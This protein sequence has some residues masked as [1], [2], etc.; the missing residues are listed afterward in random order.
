M[1]IVSRWL[2]INP[3]EPRFNF[4]QTLLALHLVLLVELNLWLV[5]RKLPMGQRKSKFVYEFLV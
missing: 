2:S 4:I 1:L 3:I 5:V